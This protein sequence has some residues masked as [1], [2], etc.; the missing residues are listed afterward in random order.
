[1]VG[2]RRQSAVYELDLAR[3]GG[4]T[5]SLERDVTVGTSESELVKPNPDRLMLII[6]NHGTGPITVSTMSPVTTA[7][8]LPLGAGSLLVLSAFDDGALVAQR[9]YT[10][11]AIAATPVTLIEIERSHL[12]G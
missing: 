3:F 6:A 5:S 4:P 12:G 7:R 10:I 11:G 2:P 9:L 1:M 8:G